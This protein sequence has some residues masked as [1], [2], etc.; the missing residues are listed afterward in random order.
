MLISKRIF[1]YHIMK[2]LRI[3]P[4]SPIS[5]KARKSRARYSGPYLDNFRRSPR[6]ILHSL[7]R[8]PLPLLRH[9]HSTE[10]LPGVSISA[11]CLLFWLWRPLKGAWLHPLSTHP[12]D[13]YRYWW[14]PSWAFHH[15]GGPLLDSLP[16][17]HSA[18]EQ[19]GGRCWRGRTV[20]NKVL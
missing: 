17:A 1:F 13:I 18:L 16:H 11:H 7:S 9:P 4:S 15:I 2:W 12:L 20:V 19:G 10:V 5:A 14:D 3:G 6:R 8:Q